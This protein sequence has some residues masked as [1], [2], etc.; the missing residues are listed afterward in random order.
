MRPLFLIILAGL[1]FTAVD[2]AHP[3]TK[4]K[5]QVKEDGRERQFPDEGLTDLDAEIIYSQ[6]QDLKYMGKFDEAIYKEEYLLRQG[7][8]DKFLYLNILKDYLEWAASAQDQGQQDRLPEIISGARKTG[9]AGYKLYP[10]F[11]ELLYQYG[12]ILRLDSAN[13]EMLDLLKHILSLDIN[14]TYGNY[15]LGN[16]YFQTG[17]YMKAKTHFSRIITYANSSSMLGLNALFTANYYLGKMAAGEGFLNPA[18]KFLEAARVFY[19]Q[20]TE[21][22]ELL[23]TYYAYTLDY[24]KATENYKQIPLNYLS[25]ESAELYASILY[26][27]GVSGLKELISEFGKT[28]HLFKALN[29]IENKDYLEAARELSQYKVNNDQTSFYIYALYR[30][31]YAAL[32]NRQKSLQYQFLMANLARVNGQNDLAV[33]LMRPLEE[34]KWLRKEVYWIIA[35]I[36]DQNKNPEEAL[37]YYQRFLSLPITPEDKLAAQL[38]MANIYYHQ[39]KTDMAWQEFQRLE[40]S[41]TNNRNKME[42]ASFSGLLRLENND[43]SHAIADL[44]R[45]YTYDNNNS[46]VYYLLATVYARQKNY[47]DAIAILEN[48]VGFYP[49]DSNINNLLAYMYAESGK[50]LEYA[51]QLVDQSLKSEP[52]N[53]AFLDTRAWILFKQD[54]KKESVR[55][56]ESLVNQLTYYQDLEG[57]DEIYLHLGQVYESLGRTQEAQDVYRSGQKINPANQDISQRLEAMGLE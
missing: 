6:A 1:I 40:E 14:D 53:L 45:A 39:Q 12:E 7:V 48:A 56:L 16:Y 8:N 13:R 11:L 25:P 30:D 55:I 54:R 31:I 23:G 17:D 46:R 36:Q 15:Y 33:A 21:I 26:Y 52:G 27:S 9:D 42:V 44:K 2:N 18:I 20:G 5:L 43:Y 38:Q 57:I 3:D 32:G 35:Q 29:K 24:N 51:L 37:K 28:S 41:Q 49:E 47:D 22:T 19:N 50:K 34:E 4:T 10:D